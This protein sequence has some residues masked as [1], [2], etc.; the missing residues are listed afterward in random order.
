MTRPQNRYIYLV[1][2]FFYLETWSHSLLP[3]LVLDSGAQGIFLPQPVEQLGLQH[4]PPLL[5][6]FTLV[7]PQILFEHF[8]IV[9]CRN[10][11]VC[12]IPVLSLSHP[13]VVTCSSSPAS[14]QTSKAVTVF[15]LTEQCLTLVG[16]VWQRTFLVNTNL[17]VNIPR[18]DTILF[19][20]FEI[21]LLI[22]GVSVIQNLWILTIFSNRKILEITLQWVIV[23]INYHGTLITIQL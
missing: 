13:C 1:G 3:K 5:S 7:K 20:F 2:L 19:F 18:S 15:P 17:K 10:N 11:P 14:Q 9:Y 16:H 21:S 12:P 4:T 6:Q 23:Y 22:I 8:K